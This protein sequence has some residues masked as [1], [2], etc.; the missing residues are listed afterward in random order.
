MIPIYKRKIG[1]CI[2]LS[3]VTLGIYNCYWWCM[4]LKNVRALQ[5]DKSSCTKE[6]LFLIFIPFYY[7]YWTFT[8]GKIIK[9]IL[10]KEGYTVKGDETKYLIFGI[11][12][13]SIVS[14]AIMQS[15]FNSL[16]NTDNP[17]PL[18]IIPFHVI[19]RNDIPFWKAMLFRVIA[20]VSAILLCSILSIIMIDANPIKFIGTMFEGAFG[21][22]ARV[23]AFAKDAA[24][25]LCIALAITPAFKMRFWNIGAE[26]QTLIGALA[27]V[28]VIQGYKEIIKILGQKYPEQVTAATSGVAGVI[29]ECALILCML[30]AAIIAGAIWGALP[31]IFKAIWGTNETLFTLMMNYVATG[32]VAY[33]LLLWTPSGSSVLGSLDEGHLPIIGHEYLLVIV[34]VLLLTAGLFVY[35]RYTK[36]GYEISVVGESENTANYI[37]I[38]VKKVIVRTMLISGAICGFAG[39]LIVGA[40]DHSVAVDSVGG[41]GFTAIMVS[42]LAMF[43]PLVMI[44]TSSF[45]TFLDRGAGQITTTF[46]IDSSF[47]DMVMGIVLF[48]IIGCEFFIGYRIKLKIR[49]NVKKATVEIP[50][51][52]NKGGSEQ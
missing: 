30:A 45:I 1:I 9:E 19:K 20:V 6:L 13:L 48:F 39:F 17:S 38:N 26:G 40:L 47:P 42:W 11:C 3:I 28:A 8:N 16:K 32:L 2:L 50:K 24:I 7:V 41:R 12:G 21:T 15:D 29:N 10:T 25:L 34:V 46:N 18:P 33:F 35:Q 43:N 22:P 4:L 31:A 51:V 27:S 36:Q 49:D 5:N 37:G 23:W 52:E 44:G 14:M